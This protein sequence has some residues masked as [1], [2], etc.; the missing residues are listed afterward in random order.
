MALWAE[1]EAR[2]AALRPGIDT[3]EM[4]PVESGGAPAAIHADA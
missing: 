1:N 4:A 3:W 2:L